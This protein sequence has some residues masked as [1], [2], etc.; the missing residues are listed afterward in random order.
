[1]SRRPR[2]A[3]GEVGSFANKLLR[4]KVR[5]TLAAGQKRSA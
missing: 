4:K 2:S 3:M 1:M 5:A